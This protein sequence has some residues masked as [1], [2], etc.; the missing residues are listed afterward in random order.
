MIFR[1]LNMAQCSMTIAKGI[2]DIGIGM[3]VGVKCGCG[4]R[5]DSGGHETKSS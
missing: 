3:P 1:L 5:D 4:A 2:M